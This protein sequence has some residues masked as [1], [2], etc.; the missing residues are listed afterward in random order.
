MINWKQ[1]RI[2]LFRNS[3]FKEKKE[4][5]ILIINICNKL[6]TTNNLCKEKIGKKS[7]KF[8]YTLIYNLINIR[9]I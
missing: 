4:M 6:K 5:K 2:L 7:F 9:E 8:N 3:F 1:L